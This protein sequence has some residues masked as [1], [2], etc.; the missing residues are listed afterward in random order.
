M[1]IKELIRNNPFRVLG[2]F[3]NDSSDIIASNNSRIKAFGA[4]GKTVAFSQDMVSVFGVTPNR[5]KGMLATSVAA[6]SSPEG[7]LINGMFWFMNQTDTDAEALAVLA[8]SGDL[9]EA[10]RIWEDGE[11]DMSS[12]QNQLMCCLLK[13][14]RSFSKA[15]QLASILYDDYGDEFIVTVSNGFEVITSDKLMA[16]F[17][18]EVVKVSDGVCRWWDKAVGRLGDWHIDLQWADAKATHCINKLYDTLNVAKSAEIHSVQSNYDIAYALMKQAEPYL[19]DLK[20]LRS[21]HP[22]LLSRYSTITDAVCE[23]ILNLEIR[24]YNNIGWFSGKADHAL[25]LER[26]CYRYASTIRLKD[27]CRLNINITMGRKDNAPLFPNG[28]PE[29]LFLESDRLK[30]NAGICAIL[31]GLLV[32]NT[33]SL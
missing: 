19:K 24:Y 26:F 2:A 22:I 15:I 33:E 27:R 20:A 13:D 25:V 7:R 21:R 11:Q 31:E 32:K 23:E 4:I 9:L 6:L 12:I 5:D 18:S 16:T 30:R 10:R 3:A 1:T 8:R 17:L 14:S 29:R 28:M